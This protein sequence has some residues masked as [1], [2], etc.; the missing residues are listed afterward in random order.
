LDA[1]HELGIYENGEESSYIENTNENFALT[2]YFR[3]YGEKLKY[4][5]MKNKP[6]SQMLEK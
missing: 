6:N 4:N 1:S 5:Q 3:E 2:S